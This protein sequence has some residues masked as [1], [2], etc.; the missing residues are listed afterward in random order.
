MKKAVNAIAPGD[1]LYHIGRMHSKLVYLAT[2]EGILTDKYNDDDDAYTINLVLD[3]LKNVAICFNVFGDVKEYVEYI[4][5]I[6]QAIYQTSM[7]RNKKAPIIVKK[8]FCLMQGCF[9]RFFNKYKRRIIKFCEE[10]YQEICFPLFKLDQEYIK[11]KRL[12]MN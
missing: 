1:K 7:H 4:A 8:S 5:S 3:A 12:D 9:A 2:V 10:E 6:N 11:F